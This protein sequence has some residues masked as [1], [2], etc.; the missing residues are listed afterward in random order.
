MSDH[1]FSP[2]TGD[3]TPLDHRLEQIKMNRKDLLHTLTAT[4]EIHLT[5]QTYIMLKTLISAV[6]AALVMTTFLVC[7]VRLAV[8]NRLTLLRVTV[9]RSHR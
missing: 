2:C 1:H 5:V 3:R 9:Q 4:E 6:T 8:S 7:N